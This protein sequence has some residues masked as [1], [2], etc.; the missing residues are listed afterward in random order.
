MRIATWNVNGIRARLPRLVPW[1]EAVAPDICAL[2]ETKCKDD[3]FP[4]AEMQALGY[5]FAH[6]GTGGFNGVALLSRV[7]L[8]DVAFGFPG[9]D[10][11]KM[12]EARCVTA[13][14]GGVRAYSL[15]IPN[16]RSLD[17]AEYP[18]KLE[19]LRHLGESIEAVAKPADP[20]VAMGDFNV[21][22]HDDDVW[23]RAAFNGSTH[24]T[25]PERDGVR[26]L[27]DWGMSDVAAKARIAK[28]DHPFTYWDYRAGM[29]HKDMGMRI[30]YVLA[31]EPIAGAITDAYVD[32]DA[33]KGSS[34]SDHAPIVIDTDF[35][36]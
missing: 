15:Y 7:G 22:L 20:V 32:R 29:F 14:A 10:D 25:E 2:Q 30:D 16:G 36:A 6:H 23:D 35:A 4:A 18:Y 13:V 31:T 12:A 19:W 3:G 17:S 27:I 24:V 33:R 8:D 1:L 5:E 26:R 21:A 34:P 9:T 28:G 11:P